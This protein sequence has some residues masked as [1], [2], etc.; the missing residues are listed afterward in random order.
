[1][2][3]ANIDSFYLL[4]LSSV[5]SLSRV[6]LCD[7][8]DCSM[9]GFL[10]IT[11]SQSLSNSCPSSQWRHPANSSSVIP[12]SSCLQS[13]PASGSLPVNQFFASGGPSIGASA[14]VL[15]INIQDWFLLG[16]TRYIFVSRCLNFF[17]FFFPRTTNTMWTEVRSVDLIDLFLILGGKHLILCAQ[18]TVRPN[19]IE[20]SVFGAEKGLLPHRARGQVAYFSPQPPK[21]QTPWRVTAKHF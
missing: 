3:F 17:F 18:C 7:P 14:S 6:R 1:M 5:Q 11:N 16:L 21:S 4:Y 19:K 9:P 15:S 10:A 20:R 2:S 12:F 13:F 8:M